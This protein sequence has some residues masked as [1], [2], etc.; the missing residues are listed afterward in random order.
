MKF[1]FTTLLMISIFFFFGCKEEEKKLNEDYQAICFVS[2]GDE[3][4]LGNGTYMNPPI[5]HYVLFLYHDTIF[6]VQIQN[7]KSTY[8]YLKYRNKG[9]DSLQSLFK[10]YNQTSLYEQLKS[11]KKNNYQGTCAPN[12]YFLSK[13]NQK[14]NFGLFLYRDYYDWSRKYSW[15]Q[16]SLTSAQFPKIYS[17]IYH[18]L[19]SKQ[20]DYFMSNEYYYKDVRTHL[21]IE[22]IEPK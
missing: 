12:G 7:E 5:I 9:K 18:T 2:N 17:T 10:K 21:R 13:S 6:Q 3:I 1:I 16:I 14:L 20:W 19:N 11:M 4:A 15:K 22:F 8:S